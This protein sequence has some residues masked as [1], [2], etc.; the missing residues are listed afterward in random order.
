MILAIYTVF[1][2]IRAIY[3]LATGF[4][5]TPLVN[6]NKLMKN[7]TPLVTVVI[8][9]WNE[10]VGIARTIHSVVR[11]GY[12][13]VEI[14]VVDDGSTDD[15]AANVKAVVKKHPHKIKLI[16]QA[17]SGKSGALNTGIA[18]AKGS[19][20]LTLDA[21]SYLE[22]GSILKMVKALANTTYG[23]AI[24]E[25][26]VGNMNSWLGRAQH[27]EYSI[28]FHMKRAQHVFDSAYIFP[29]A[30]TM[31]RTELLSEIGKFTDYSSTEDL[32]ISM[33]IKIAGHKIAY[34]DSA[35]CVTEGAS[36]VRDLLNQRTRWRHGYLE[37]L[38]HHKNFL[39]SPKKGW[40]LTLIDLPMQLLDVIEVFM[41]PVV[42]AL[43]CYLLTI[44]ANPL[45]LVLAYC[46]IPF[47]LLMLGDVREKHRQ[48]SLWVFAV[49]LM[50]LFIGII[51]YVAL[52]K[53][54][55]RTIRRRRT[56]WTVWRR[57]G[58]DN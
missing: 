42:L 17:N 5:Y 11:N 31:F 56:S 15:T 12:R 29:G 18:Q 37:C 27:Y 24:G 57:T 22:P 33:R 51:E 38:W 25:V 14:V 32:D 6:T 8:P 2:F 49:P 16:S 39:L 7:Y 43:L 26:V 58:A 44:N 45:G 34:V 47:T 20:V 50:L 53:S 21:D 30:L 54:L 36:T 28:S 52:L 19:L 35:I 9:A 1:G 23:V 13:R 55:Y 3:R 40:Y 41:L 10:E 46:L 4:L 48:L